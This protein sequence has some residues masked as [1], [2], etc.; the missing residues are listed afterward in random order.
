MT[1]H[2]LVCDIGGTHLKYAL[3]NE[4]GMILENHHIATPENLADF[5]QVLGSIIEVYR[6][7][8][9]GI[10]FSAPGKIDTAQGIIEQGGSLFYLNQ[11]AL[12]AEIKERYDLPARVINDGKAAALAEYWKGSLKRQDNSA[13]IILGTGVGGGLILDGQLRHGPHSQA[14][15]LSFMQLNARGFDISTMSGSLGSAVGM[16]KAVNQAVGHLDETDGRAAFGAIEAGHEKAKA[17]F[18]QYCRVIATIILNT[19]TILDLE[20]IAIG[21]GISAQPCLLVEINRQYDLMLEE[22]PLFKAVLTR[23]AILKARFG[24][25]ANLIGALYHYLQSQAL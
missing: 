20:A 8:I 4:E 11:V 19:H 25:Q 6:Q 23:P 5:W 7:D 2:Y 22:S 12:A 3:M 16:V 1:A 13:A 17:I 14:G 10:A 24:N 9:N 15:E 18:E 21:G